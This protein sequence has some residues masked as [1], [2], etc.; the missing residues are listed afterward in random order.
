MLLWVRKKMPCTTQIAVFVG[1]VSLVGLIHKSLLLSWYIALLKLLHMSI[2]RVPW[3]VAEG[4]CTCQA[5][6][7]QCP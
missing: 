1:L 2:P 6:L 7:G 5:C 3:F 4:I